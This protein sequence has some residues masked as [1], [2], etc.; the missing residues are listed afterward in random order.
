MRKAETAPRTRI[1]SAQAGYDESL[2]AAVR[3]IMDAFP[4]DWRGKSVL[5]KPNIL[6]PHPPEKA[7]T[8]HPALVR[9]VVAA[10]RDRGAEVLVGDNPGVGGYGRSRSSARE[11]GLLDAAGDCF[12]TLGRN[13]VRKKLS[14]RNVPSVAVSREVLEADA[15]VSLPKLKT[16][17]LTVLTGAI[18]NTFGYLVGGD[19]MAV[20]ARC[21]TPRSFAEALV[22]VFALRPPDLNIMDA[23]EAMQGNGPANGQPVHLGRILA[24]DDAVGLDAAVLHMLGQPV[25]SAPHVEIAGRRGLGE[26]N[27]SRMEI[28]GRLPPVSGFRF[29]KTF[30]PGLAGFVL[31]RYLSRWINCVP[32]IVQERCMACG[33]CASHCPS[34]A[35][36]M[37]RNGPVLNPAECIH[38]YCCQEMCPEDAI[39]LSGRVLNLLRRQ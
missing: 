14:S 6:A 11:C 30:V 7:V 25:R 3:E 37:T 13:P 28:A 22:D 19:K 1:V 17:S 21:P 5:V 27:V 15:V 2:P 33:L 29:P 23:V 35:M 18:K 31:N 10:L 16:H 9:A 8:T 12:V 24:S 4:R 26:T 36:R 20:H 38:C 32:E 34:G 39:S